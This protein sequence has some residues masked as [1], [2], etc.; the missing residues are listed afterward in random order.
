MN[1]RL[2]TAAVIVADLAVSGRAQTNSSGQDAGSAVVP[3]APVVLRNTGT[4]IEQRVATNESGQYRFLN[5]APG[6][7]TLQISVTG[8][9]TVN[10]EPFKLDV[11]QN[12]TH[13]VRLEVGEISQQ[14]EVKD[15]AD[16]VQ[17]ASSVW[18]TGV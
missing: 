6:S 10:L 18:G 4:G 11:N 8:F 9:K 3:Q 5:V 1:L 7:Y 14:G 15:Q 17:R 12:L 13:D 2:L 16:L